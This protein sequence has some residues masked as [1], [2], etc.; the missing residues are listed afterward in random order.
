MKSQ[1]NSKD[2]PLSVLLLVNSRYLSIGALRHYLESFEKMSDHRFVFADGR[3]EVDLD[4]FDLSEFDV[5]AVH[6]SIRVCF[7]QVAESLEEALADFSGLRVLFI[8]DEY[9]NTEN[10]RQW[11]LKNQIH[12]VFTVVPEDYIET[13][14]PPERFGSTRFVNV[15][16]GYVSTS[17]ASG[18]FRPKPHADRSLDIVYRGRPANGYWL[19]DLYLE[20][21]T[22]AQHVEHRARERGM[23]VD[24]ESSDDARIY[25]SEWYS[26]LSSGRS[27]LAT[28]SGSNVF[29]EQGELKTRVQ[30][31]LAESPK[32]SYEEVK[33]SCGIVEHPVVRMN[34]VSPRIFEAIGLRTALIC[35]EGSY[36]G[37]IEPEKHFLPLR[38]DF[39]NLDDV[40]NQLTNRHEVEAMAE[41][42][43]E[44][45]VASG[46]YSFGSFVAKVD[47]EIED[48][49]LTSRCQVQVGSPESGDSA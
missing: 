33:A 44:D 24:I 20:K 29:D 38:K 11:I 37:V 19:G 27:S 13:I 3:E 35:F 17:L 22:I 42:A 32:A 23:N 14:Y 12:L 39:A 9:Q 47:R 5:V 34:Q 8:Q 6:Y 4:Q 41:R 46:E 25:G 49:R 31:K 21:A 40:L 36:S 7:G 43:F 1:P 48:L 30:T 18:S 10:A 2:R 45:V 15:L 16:T 28:E 26:F